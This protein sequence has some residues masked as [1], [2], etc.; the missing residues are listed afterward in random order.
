MPPIAPCRLIVTILNAIFRPMARLQ[1]QG[2]KPGKNNETVAVAEPEES[3]FRYYVPGEKPRIDQA[4]FEL[5]LL[6]VLRASGDIAD[7]DEVWPR[8]V[9]ALAGMNLLRLSTYGPGDVREAIGT[10]G[11][12]FNARMSGQTEAIIGWAESFWRIRQIYGT[13]RQYIRSF[14][15]EG[16][17]ALMEDLKARLPGLSQDFLTG[18]LRDAG[19]KVP[20]P[21]KPAAG[22]QQ[23]QPRRP[24]TP[25]TRSGEQRGRQPQPQQKPESTS[26]D[27]R[28]RQRGRSGPRPAGQQPAQ[29]QRPQ[30]IPATAAQAAATEAPTESAAKNPE[31]QQ[32]RRNRRRFFRRRRSGGG[33][34][35]GG[36]SAPPAAS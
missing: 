21:E 7:F 22:R 28:R 23:Q 29:P 35:P 34:K 17:D 33:E 5:L 31:Q 13:F 19:E 9:Q 26:G 4:F 11:G 27:R 14:E 6:K 18:Y 20:V 24:P 25:E 2:Q 3:P 16:F 1:P 10:V 36:A 15:A 32:R 12:E 30:R 8:A